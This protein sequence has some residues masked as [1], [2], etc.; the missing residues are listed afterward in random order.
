MFSIF[1]KN[2]QSPFFLEYN[3]EEHLYSICWHTH[4]TNDKTMTSYEKV[5]IK[6]MKVDKYFNIILDM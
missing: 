2:N 1:A 6:D 3:R 5:I 4:P